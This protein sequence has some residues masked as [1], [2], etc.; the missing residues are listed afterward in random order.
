MAQALYGGVGSRRG[1][2]RNDACAEI[3]QVRA[4]DRTKLT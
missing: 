3:Y 2:V 4:D 1:T